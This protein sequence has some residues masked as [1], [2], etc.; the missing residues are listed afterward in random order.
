MAPGQLRSSLLRKLLGPRPGHL[1]HVL[2]I[3]RAE[4]ALVGELRPQLR[5]DA[6][7]D[8]CPPP[9]GSRRSRIVRPISQYIRSISVFTL[10]CARTCAPRTIDLR[11]STIS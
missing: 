8:L 11:S 2:Q 1:L 10:S 3:A 6:L 4:P 5:G 9:L 7:D